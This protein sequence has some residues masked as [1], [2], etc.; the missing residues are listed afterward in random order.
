VA[1]GLLIS[2]AG[3]YCSS[4]K[5]DERRVREPPRRPCGL[6]IPSSLLEVLRWY[7][8]TPQAL[9]SMCGRW[10]WRSRSWTGCWSER[11]VTDKTSTFAEIM[12]PDRTSAA[13]RV[14]QESAE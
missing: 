1:L 7:Q 14:E 4:I 10:C 13:N 3:G 6:H 9:D 5:A 12:T 8:Q 11:Q 2:R